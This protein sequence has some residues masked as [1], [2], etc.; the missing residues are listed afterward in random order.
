MDLLVS[1]MTWLFDANLLATFCQNVWKSEVLV[2]IAPL[3]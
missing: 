2:M 3:L 1:K